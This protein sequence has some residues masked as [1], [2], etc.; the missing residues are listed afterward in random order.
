M[1]RAA[2]VVVLLLLVACIVTA[3]HIDCRNCKCDGLSLRRNLAQY[4]MSPGEA[5]FSVSTNVTEKQFKCLKNCGFR[6]VIIRAYLDD[7]NGGRVGKCGRIY[8]S[9]LCMHPCIITL[10]DKYVS[11]NIGNA[12]AAGFH[13]VDV[14]MSPAVGSSAK[15][16]STQVEELGK[17]YRS[18]CNHLPGILCYSY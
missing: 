6:F 8:N 14:Y 13:Y 4:C 18:A 5:G 17:L 3:R 10:A 11:S 2:N 9:P 15:S 1:Y 12:R 16:A 7:Q